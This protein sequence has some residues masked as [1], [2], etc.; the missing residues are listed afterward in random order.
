[1]IEG[2]DKQENWHG[3]PKPKLKRSRMDEIGLKFHPDVGQ[4][5]VDPYVDK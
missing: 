2:I 4:F 1:L 5:L 3:G